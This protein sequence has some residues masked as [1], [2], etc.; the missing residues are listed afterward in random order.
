MRS[1]ED[2]IRTLR[3]AAGH[4]QGPPRVAATA[5][6]RGSLA[7][8][9]AARRRARRL[10][11]RATVVLAAAAVVIVA[12]GMAAILSRGGEQALPAV[13][14]TTS[15]SA[16][17][18]IRPAAEVWPQAVFTMPAK[19][20]DGWKYRPVT[21]LSATEVLLS[22][23]SAFEK[24]GR[25][26]VYDTTAKR[27]RVLGDVPAPKDVK[28]Y[29]AQDFEVGERH[30]AWYGR[31]PNNADKWADFWIMPRDGGKARR[32]RQVTG[33]MAEVERIGV[34]GDSVV[35]SVKRGGV[36]RVPIAGGAPEPIAG[37]E[38]LRL[39]SWPWAAG[40]E[41]DGAPGH[42]NQNRLV[43]LETGE[44]VTVP[45]PKGT[46]GLICGPVWCY[47][48]GDGSTIIQ[49][50][51]GSGRKGLPGGMEMH[52]MGQLLGDRF[53]LLTA[54][55]S[56]DPGKE[57]VSLV[58]TYDPATGRIGG[59]SRFVQNGGAGFGLGISSSPTTIVYWD[60]DLK[61]EVVCTRKKGTNVCDPKERGGGKELTVLNLAAVTAG[62]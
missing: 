60:E 9:V 54:Y 57:Y 49:R 25:L 55:R 28:G 2:L 24:A 21:G 41:E 38:G 34:T 20:E 27:T 26:E 53:A 62:S 36:Y 8:A 37:T 4:V 56:G 48:Q 3:S 5:G 19:A 43:N 12:G 40:Y 58:A 18:Q 13:S 42:A 7:G 31:T 30:I 32:L 35:W 52:G 47:G 61:Y 59:M 6:G 16:Q 17:A 44:S 33:T 29:F 14:A 22:V 1:E 50:H 46:T 39:A 11:Q 23:E 51:D 45:A 10:R 15:T